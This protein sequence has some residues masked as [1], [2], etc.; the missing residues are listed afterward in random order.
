[1]MVMTWATATWLLRGWRSQVMP[2]VL[3][4]DGWLSAL[5][6]GL[7]GLFSGQLCYFDLLMAQ[8]LQSLRS[9]TRR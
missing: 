4:Q 6:G 1:M 7:P 5:A 9:R 3:P 2:E 8:K